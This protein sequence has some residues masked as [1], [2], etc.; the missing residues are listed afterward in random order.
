[1]RVSPDG[2]A[3]D[4]SPLIITGSHLRARV[5]SSGSES[6]IVL[7]G[8]RDVSTIVVHTDGGITL[9]AET[10]VFSWVSDTS[11]AVVW[12]GATF[13]VGWTY[14][15][16]DTNRIGTAHVTRSGLPFDY[17]FTAAAAFPSVFWGWPAIAVSEAGDAAFVVSEGPPQPTSSLARARIY[18]ASEFVPMPPPPPAPRNVVSYLGGTTARIDWQS[19]PASGFAIEV[20]LAYNNTWSLYRTVPGDARTTTIYASIGTLVRIRAFGQGG[21]SEGTV[22]SIGSMQRRRAAP[23]TH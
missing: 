12:D 14:R 2:D 6:L 18:L 10:P 21:L 8:Y 20:W 19:D 17:R 7:D 13:T 16:A 5:A 15:G 11:S 22:T 4:S 9:G 3:I 23:T 1:M